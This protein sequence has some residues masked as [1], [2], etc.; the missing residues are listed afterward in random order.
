MSDGLFSKHTALNA[1]TIPASAE[2][3]SQRYAKLFQQYS[4]LKAQH[5]V[6]K[7][8]VIKE[9]ASNVALQGN[10]KEKEKELRKLQEQLDLLSFHNERLTKRIQ[11]VQE[12]DQIRENEILHEELTER[13][14]EFTNTIN[15]LLKQIQDLEEKVQELETG[16]SLQPGVP[17][18]EPQLNTEEQSL[19]QQ[20]D[21]LKSKLAEK[22]SLLNDLEDN[23]QQN[24]ARLLSEIDSLRAILLAKVGDIKNVGLNDILP[25]DS[26]SLKELEEE[27]KKYFQSIQDTIVEVLHELASPIPLPHEIAEK[28]AISHATWRKEHEEISVELKKLKDQLSQSLENE[29]KGQAKLAEYENEIKK[30]NERYEEH[31]SQQLEELNGKLEEEKIKHASV[32]EGYAKKIQQLEALNE[33]LEKENTRLQQ[34]IELIHINRQPVTDNQ[35]QTETIAEQNEEKFI[36]PTKEEEEEEEVFVY[37]GMDAPPAAKEEK[38]D[39]I[40][41]LKTFYEQKINNLSEKLQMTDSKALRFANMYKMMKERLASEEKEKQQ[42]FTEIE[43]LNKELKHVQD[44]LATTESNYQKQID[45]MTEYITNLQ[46]SAE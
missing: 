11:A 3:L 24:D 29:E 28:L 9:Q 15:N 17:S 14:F 44:L 42:M 26:S 36:Y 6:L 25:E 32:E 38:E 18:Q 5:A 43:K 22:T 39:E 2:E 31:L 45:A 8:A 35:T 30:L 46:Q 4:R 13:Q 27:A 34:E 33:K 40:A 20:I 41:I 19:M 23:M 10:V 1:G 37:T 16:Q 21:V 12:S 7:K